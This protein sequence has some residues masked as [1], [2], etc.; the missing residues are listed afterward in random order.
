MQLIARVT[1]GIPRHINRLC[2]AVIL[3]A[4]ADHRT[5]VDAELVLSVAEE[6]LDLQTVN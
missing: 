2:R 5:E 6:L 4:Q 1:N 3:A